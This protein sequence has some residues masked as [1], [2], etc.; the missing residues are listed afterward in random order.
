MAEA[1]ELA[2]IAEAI[3]RADTLL[4]PVAQAFTQA[5]AA[6]AAS[7]PA[8]EVSA[9][10]D[11]AAARLSTA[12]RR[13][14]PSAPPAADASNARVRGAMADALKRGGARR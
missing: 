2:G 7:K 11:S 1:N 4:A 10:I 6:V 14:L 9:L 8:A 12:T 13:T 5:S 3:L